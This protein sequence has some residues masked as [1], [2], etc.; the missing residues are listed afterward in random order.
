MNTTTPPQRPFTTIP[1]VAWFTVL[2]LMVTEV[3]VAPYSAATFDTARDLHWAWQIASGQSF[4]AVGPLLA[5]NIYLTPL[6]F[7]VLAPPI[8]LFGSLGS[9]SI[10]VGIL[11]ALKFPLALLFGHRLLNWRLGCLFAAAL[12][13]PSLA[14]ISLVTWTHISIAG[15][16]IILFALALLADWHR[17]RRKSALLMG[18]TVAI[19]L[20]AHPTLI[21]LT[22]PMLLNWIRARQKVSRA[23][24]MVMPAI[25][26]LYPL[27]LG[28]GGDSMSASSVASGALNAGSILNLPVLLY[29]S[30]VYG[31]DGAIQLFAHE[32]PN[33]VWL[34]RAVVIVLVA[35]SAVGWLQFGLS[36]N[37]GT[38][39]DDGRKTIG[40]LLV[41]GMLIYALLVALMRPFTWWYMMLGL[42]PLMA[43]LLA[44]GWYSIRWRF[45]SGFIAIGLI[46]I[47]CTLLFNLIATGSHSH[48]R[49]FAVGL[50]DLKQISKQRDVD[51]SP[52]LPLY[53][54]DRLAQHLCSADG[55]I[56]LHGTL[57]FVMDP[58]AALLHDLHCPATPEWRLLGQA[59]PASRHW[60]GLRSEAAADAGLSALYTITGMTLVQPETIL[61]P[62]TS[63][64][65]G[66][67]ASEQLRGWAGAE[68]QRH[69]LEYTLEGR[70]L[71]SISNAFFWQAQ[72]T[73]HR[74]EA[75]GKP[76]QLLADDEVTQVY[77]C[78]DCRPGDRANWILEFSAPTGY[79]PDIVTLEPDIASGIKGTAR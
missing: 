74:I 65:L 48:S 75:N 14:S 46:I 66:N 10:W 56:T 36:R 55:A 25:L 40:L 23:L 12:I 76:A 13:M 21:A 5:Q 24:L 17:P 20:Q 30:I 73:W 4:P 29:Q 79:P 16:T 50:I 68:I 42:P 32:N 67:P 39:H 18:L 72:Q 44:I 70:Q 59:G 7:Y 33:T 37:T 28:L 2:L 77:A 64:A 71:I 26:G 15:T 3:A 11:G 69:S 31:T 34:L 52:W 53:A 57:A 35:A 78:S 63:L 51:D 38:G 49:Y 43:L 60:L 61:F 9:V 19:M 41:A 47:S 8:V 62:K 27:W 54:Q 22:W 45:R 58:T 6:W 1:V